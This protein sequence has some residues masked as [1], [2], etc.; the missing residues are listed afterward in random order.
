M[1]LLTSPKKPK[2]E[3][4]SLKEGGE[5]LE[6]A[7]IFTVEG[8]AYLTVKTVDGVEYAAKKGKK[9]IEY[10]EKRQENCLLKLEK[11]WKEK[12]LG[13]QKNSTSLEN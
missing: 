1:E 11:I 5:G 6:N 4:D 12:N 2:K 10:V 7:A 8:V 9:G 3:F 13:K